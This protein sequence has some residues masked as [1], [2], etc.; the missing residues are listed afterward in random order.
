MIL[1]IILMI[2]VGSITYLSISPTDTIT[3]GND[4]LSHIIAYLFLMINVGLIY[5]PVRKHFFIATILAFLYSILMECLQYYVPGRYMS[6][7]DG[8]ANLSGIL[9]GVIATIYFYRPITKML[10]K[11]KII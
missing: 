8:L 3:I 10:E 9:L 1:R 4:K 11:T 7:Y 2:V 5:F 6:F